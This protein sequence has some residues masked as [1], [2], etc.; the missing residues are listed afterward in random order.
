V[1]AKFSQLRRLNLLL[2]RRIDLIRL[3]ESFDAF[4][5]GLRALSVQLLGYWG[6]AAIGVYLSHRRKVE[7]SH[8]DDTTPAADES[9]PIPDASRLV[10]G[11]VSL[12]SLYWN[13][14]YAFFITPPNPNTLLA[15]TDLGFTVDSESASRWL[16]K[17]Q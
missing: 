7:L 8:S 12:T 10:I 5:G 9:A 6:T 11:M 17:C 2:E 4:K 15:L 1:V 13:F 3:L 14:P 16:A